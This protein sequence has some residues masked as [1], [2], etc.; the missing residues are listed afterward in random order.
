MTRPTIA[1]LPRLAAHLERERYDAIV[2]RS[3]I[4]FTYLAGLAFPGTLGRHLELADSPR[5]VFVVWPRDGAPAV[6]VN[7]LGEALT[8]RDGS[9]ERVI[10]YNNNTD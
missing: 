8:R 9:I 2:V 6:I 10:G 7:P 3:P 4:N 1:N 5:P